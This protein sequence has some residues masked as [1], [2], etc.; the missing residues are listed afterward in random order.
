MQLTLVI[1]NVGYSAANLLTRFYYLL[2]LISWTFPQTHVFLEIT[3]VI[4]QYYGYSILT[5]SYGFKYGDML[6]NNISYNRSR[7]KPMED[8][9]VQ[10][11]DRFESIGKSP[12]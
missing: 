6:K 2:V 3:T 8:T 11:F 7:R 9:F 1:D 10:P 4:T 5:L 12:L